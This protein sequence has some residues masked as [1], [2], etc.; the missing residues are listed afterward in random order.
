[1]AR[2]CN[3]RKIAS[4]PGAATEGQISPAEELGA[5]IVKVFPGQTVGGPQFVRAV[6]A[7]SPWHRLMPTGGVDATEASLTEWIVAGAAAVGMGSKRLGPD[8]K[9]PAF[10][11]TGRQDWP[12][13]RV[14]GGGTRPATCMILN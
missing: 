6:M 8:R 4:I 7:P 10:R 11:W 3:R 12:V 5:E 13:H 9:R 2:L 14:G 1:M